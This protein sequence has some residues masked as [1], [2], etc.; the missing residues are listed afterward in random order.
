MKKIGV[1]STAFLLIISC[2]GTGD[3]VQGPNQDIQ[4]PQ[5]QPTQKP[6]EGPGSPQG[7]GGP[8]PKGQEGF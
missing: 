5:P 2:G 3:S 8:G 1:I 7:P 6:P 4:P